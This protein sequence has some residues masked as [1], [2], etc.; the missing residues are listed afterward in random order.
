MLRARLIN[1]NST[2]NNVHEFTLHDTAPSIFFLSDKQSLASCKVA[3]I[4]VLFPS[5][6]SLFASFTSF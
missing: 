6:P 1:V 3:S 4:V 5:R 2:V